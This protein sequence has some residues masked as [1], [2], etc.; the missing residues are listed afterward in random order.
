MQK[1]YIIRTLDA[2]EWPKYRDIRLR[3]LA[4][5]PDAFGS[6]LAA[7]QDRTPD[8]WAARLFAA[9]DSDQNHLLIAELAGAAQGLLWA[10]LDAG[11]SAVVNIFQMWVAPESRGHGIA[12]ALLHE[13]L[14][15]ARSRNARVVQL[16][17]TC[18]DTPAMR[19]YLRA[20]FQAFGT[21]EPLRLGSS[22]LAQ[23]M[24]LVLDESELQ[25]G[26]DCHDP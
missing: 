14:I 10:R 9:V 20:G 2:H 1:P 13:A 15:W 4:D 24:R 8:E 3:A 22:V 25:N 12:A 23:S 7:E 17:V 11:N 6:S 18:G 19:L 16:G 21:P 26:I 5:A